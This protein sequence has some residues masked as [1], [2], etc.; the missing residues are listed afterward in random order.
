M[1]LLLY[2]SRSNLVWDIHFGS[3]ENK[4]E[5]VPIQMSN[6]GV[7][8]FFHMLKWDKKM[9]WKGPFLQTKASAH[10]SDR[11]Q[12]INFYELITRLT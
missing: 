11:I 2:I 7:C 5:M 1:F 8:L 4:S 10:K 3:F 6:Q 9:F 12:L